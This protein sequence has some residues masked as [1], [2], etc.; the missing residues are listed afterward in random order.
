MNEI[1]VNALPIKLGQFLKLIN[2]VQDG[3][4]AKLLIVDKF[5]SINGIITTQRGKKLFNRDVVEIKDV[6]RYRVLSS[7]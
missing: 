1:Q 7:S 5:V 3:I 6:G 2:I 4:E